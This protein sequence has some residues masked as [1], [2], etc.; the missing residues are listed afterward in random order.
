MYS[1]AIKLIDLIGGD[2]SYKAKY[3]RMA[4]KNNYFAL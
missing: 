1:Q 2:T 4:I 3:F